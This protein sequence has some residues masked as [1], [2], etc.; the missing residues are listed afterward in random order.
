MKGDL[1]D[2]EFSISGVIL[3]VII[4][5]IAKASTS[6]FALLGAIIPEGEDLQYVDFAPGSTRIAEE[7]TKNLETIAKVLYDRPGLKMDIRGSF[8][9][10]LDRGILHEKQFELL[11]KNEKYKKLSGKKETVPTLDEITIGSDEYETLLKKAYKE[12]DFQKPKNVL[13]FSKKL[14]PEEME[15]LLRDNII[16]TDD[17]LRLLAIERANGVKSFLVETGPV[18]P[19]R[20]FIV[21][22]KKEEGENGAQRAEMIIK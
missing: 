14:P 20:I 16:I 12:A 2:P 19:E 3:K 17:D 8:N 21:E 6:P 4:N 22:P 9:A 10:E 5:L 15:K 11:L 18:E 13:G 7:Y 1:D